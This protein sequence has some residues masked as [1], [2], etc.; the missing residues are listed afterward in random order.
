M[1]LDIQYVQYQDVVPVRKIGLVSGFY[2]PVYDIYGN[3]FRNVSTVLLNG[4]E[5]E[6]FLVLSRTRLVAQVPPRLAESPLKQVMVLS[7]AFTATEKSQLVFRFSRTGR[8]VGGL[9]KLVQTFVKVLLTTPGSD[10]YDAEHGGNL[11]A[12]QKSSSGRHDKNLHVGAFAA[13]VA[14]AEEQI[15]RVQATT[16]GL[17]LPERLLSASLLSV[18]FD[19]QTLSVEGRI[20]LVSMA[21]EEALANLAA[22][23]KEAA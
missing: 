3:D 7:D 13:A 2:P 5:A 20:R 22:Q 23:S 11:M 4:V 18:N 15:T 12:L 14:R 6:E 17:T 1:S 19:P 21:G 9:P 10:I 16:R 8:L